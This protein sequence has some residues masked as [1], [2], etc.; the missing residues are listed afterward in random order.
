ML[1]L[2]YSTHKAKP[3]HVLSGKNKIDLLFYFVLIVY[4]IL[5]NKDYK[6]IGIIDI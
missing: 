2:L 3:G 1:F 4:Y 5:V 6:K